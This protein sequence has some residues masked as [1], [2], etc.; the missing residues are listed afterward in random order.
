M[1]ERISVVAWAD[2]AAFGRTLAETLAAQTL[3][4]KLELIWVSDTLP[5]G[6]PT[7]RFA[8]VRTIE[9]PRGASLGTRKNLGI[10]AA[11]GSWIA[12]IGQGDAPEP[13]TLERLLAAA[14]RA[15]AQVSVCDTEW[16]DRRMHT[17]YP[18]AENNLYI[19]VCA[20]EEKLITAPGAVIAAEDGAIAAAKLFRREL[21]LRFPF[22]ES[23]QIGEDAS[24]VLPAL[25]DAE[26]IAYADDC[27]YAFSRPR[28]YIESRPRI[29]NALDSAEALLTAIEHITGERERSV[30]VATKLLPVLADILCMGEALEHRKELCALLERLPAAM[31]SLRDDNPFLAEL[32]AHGAGWERGAVRR[33]RAWF[34]SDQAD[35]ASLYAWS[36]FQPPVSIVIPVYN[37]A[38]YMREAI[39]SALAQTYRS[40]EVIVVNDGSSDGGAT[41]RIARSYGTR[42]RYIPKSNGG[43]ATAL[44]TGIENMR[45]EYFSW[46]SHDDAYLP[47]K[48]EN[49]VRWLAL[50]EDRATLLTES[51]RIVD[52]CGKYSCT[53][54]LQNQYHAAQLQNAL[55]SVIRGGIHGCTLLIHRSHFAR[56]GMFDPAFPTTQDYDLWFRMFKGQPLCYAYA[57]NIL[58]R[59]HQRQGSRLAGHHLQECNENWIRLS[60]SLDTDERVV[61]DGSLKRFYSNMFDFLSC[62]TDWDDAILY[63]AQKANALG[64]ECA[65]P[66]RAEQGASTEG[67]SDTLYRSH[68]WRLFKPLRAYQYARRPAYGGCTNK[69]I[70]FVRYLRNEEL[71]CQSDEVIRT[72]KCW[73]LTAPLRRVGALLRRVRR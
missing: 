12:F 5:E 18:L 9:P 24:A 15:G 57:N 45:G 20:D 56:V 33:L 48:V 69:P 10:C 30:A 50:L 13:Y 25:A 53:I 37:G 3:A 35:I 36:D 39:D 27:A 47:R 38:D 28:V 4:P 54:D 73:Q 40:I 44:N 60:E 55:F 65:I 23:V 31:P 42:I 51:Y 62:E 29:L 58:V 46:L 19:Q 34:S 26:T 72:R 22:A 71:D 70:L 61:L 14:E 59:S 2:E 41:E 32:Y 6:F 1:D 11:A 8:E 68:S 49:E 21:L 7:D 43:V 17:R 52:A 64:A 16:V 63:T 67:F 66:E